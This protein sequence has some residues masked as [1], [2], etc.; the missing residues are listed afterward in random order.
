MS[1]R[2]SRS[3]GSSE[4]DAL[5]QQPLASLN[6][7]HIRE[8]ALQFGAAHQCPDP[9]TGLALYGPWSTDDDPGPAQIR[10]GI[11]GT[12]PTIQAV[13]AWLS[14]CRAQVDPSTSFDADP[15]LFP[16][17]PG[18]E[19]PGAFACRLEYPQQLVE[20]LRPA[21]IARCTAA[22]GRTPAVEAMAG[23]VRDRLQALD[24]RESRP[25]VV[26]VALPQE[27]RDAAGGGRDRPKRRRGSETEKRQLR[28][29]FLDPRPLEPFTPSR[30][31]HRAIKAEGMRFKLP[32]Q[33]IWPAALAGG[34]EVQDDAT[35]AWNFCT[36]L[37][38]K[39][40]GVP[41]RVTGLVKNTCYVGLSFYQPIDHIGE[42]Q[43]SMAQAFSDKGDGMVL[44]GTSFKWDL[45]QGSP[46]LSKDAARTLI[47]NV[48]DQ[49]RLHLQQT[50]ARVV[51]HKSSSF[52][53][54]EIAG[55]REALDGKVDYHD[56]LSVRPGAIRFLRLG[57]EP[58][59]RGTVIEVAPRRYVVYTRG[60]VPFLRVYPGLRIP[61]PLEVTHAE[62]TGAITELLREFFALTR[63][64]WNSA[65]FASAE[66]ITL[67]FSRSVGLILSELPS[68]VQPQRSFRFYM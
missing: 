68:D 66:P 28:L 19:G 34:A 53:A 24:E 25:H 46:R 49:Y 32:T 51:I 38:Y 64:N 59:I 67:G 39:A 4:A 60:Y 11:I 55:M 47:A 44:R 63:L 27:V 18:M 2:R 57:Q 48:L 26:V 33:L 56:F 42:L 7:W 40:G 13:Q 1:K 23:I 35:R 50:P 9:K 6:T 36:A 12:G 54:E 21:D 8:P 30:T 62:G 15:Y 22:S 16:S 5:L 58:P 3:K 37:Y 31:L 14:R 45:R 29:A 61:Q 65:D 10:V 43:T 20:T 41:W 52:S 17:F